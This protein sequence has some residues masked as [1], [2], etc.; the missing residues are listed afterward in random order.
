MV[1]FIVLAAVIVLDR[2]VKIMV[3]TGMVP[4]Q[5]IPVVENVFHITYIRNTGAAFSIFEGQRTLLIVIPLVIMAV[6]LVLLIIKR[7]TWH[8]LLNLAIS[9]ICAGGIGNLADRAVRGY[10]VDMFDFRFF[11][12]FN[13]ADIFVCIGC[14]LIVLYVLVI[15]GRKS[16]KSKGK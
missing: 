15:D 11:P 16:K 2:I 6:G 10:V 12:V 7:K 9:M 13:V 5:S 4:G 8:P 1:Y 3:S 14:G